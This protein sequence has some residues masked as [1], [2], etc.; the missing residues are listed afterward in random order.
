M[1]RTV[2]I[3]VFIAAGHASAAG[4]KPIRL[5]NTE[6]QFQEF[7]ASLKAAA[8]HKDSAAVY[9]LLAPDYYIARDFGGTFDP[10]AS[11]IQNFSA[12]FEFN[13]ANLRPEYKD[14]GWVEFRR[15]VSG[16]NFEQKADGQ[17]CTTRGDREAK[18]FPHSQ[19]CF[20][21]NREGWRIQGH[22]NAGD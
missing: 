9:L 15:A 21:K 8:Q 10:S 3:L 5:P 13:S 6:R 17:L 16:K 18:P 7:I 2:L 11:A 20:R 19:L 22:I 12:N 14:Y 4:S 1:I